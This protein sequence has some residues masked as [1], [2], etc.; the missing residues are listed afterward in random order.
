MKKL[1]RQRERRE[2]GKLNFY[3]YVRNE[4]ESGN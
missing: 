1:K 4:R 3:G 2:K